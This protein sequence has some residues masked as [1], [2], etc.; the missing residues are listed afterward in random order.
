MNSRWRANRIGLIDFW[1]YDE[2]EFYFLDGRILLRGANGSGKSVTM[3]SFIPLLLDGNMRPERLD[4]FGSKARKMENYLLEEGD[5]RDERTGYLYME[6]KRQEV[7]N[8]ITIGIGMRARRNKKMDVWYFAITDGRRIGEDFFLYKD[9]NN[10]IAYS[11]QELKNRIAEGGKFFDSQREYAEYVNKTLFGFETTDEY[12]EMLE[13]LIQLRTPKLSKDFK[14][15]I[16]NEILSSSL[17]TLTEDDLRP[18]SEA[19]ENMDSLKTMLDT[20]KESIQAARQIGRVFGQY[21]S[22]VLYDK[23]RFYKNASDE[24]DYLIKQTQDYSKQ[25]DECTDRLNSEQ[26]K[27]DK[28]IQEQEI[29]LEEKKSLDE[30]DA[31]KLKEEEQT[32]LSELKVNEQS[33]NEKEKQHQDKRQRRVDIEN[34]INIQKSAN[35]QSS[36]VIDEFLEEMEEQ[37]QDFVFDEFEFLKR[38]FSDNRE[39]ACDFKSHKHLLNDYYNKVEAGIDI[40]ENERNCKKEY[41]EQLSKTD[42]LLKERD[43]AEKEFGQA[44]ILFGEAKSEWLEKAYKWNRENK[45]LNIT[46]EGMQILSRVL[47]DFK[48]GEDFSEIKESIRNFYQNREDELR[49]EQRKAIQHHDEI[50]QQY[51]DRKSELIEWEEKKD[52]EPVHSQAVIDNRK[53]LDE[54]KIPYVQFYKAVD[55]DKSLSDEQA[56]YLEE[57]LLQ[58]GILDALIISE[59]YRERVLDI[60]EGLCDKYIFTDVQSVK[61][62]LLNVLD[63]DN[64]DSDINLYQNVY[65]VLSAV[66][67]KCLNSIQHSDEIKDTDAYNNFE[68]DISTWIAKDGK[69]RLGILEGT[70]T[71]QH[72]AKYIGAKA[73][74]RYRMQEIE[75]LRGECDLLKEE[76]SLA[77]KECERKAECLKQIKDEWNIFPAGDDVKTAAR[78][79]SDKEYEL[80][81]LQVQVEKQRE[82]LEELRQQLEQIHT[83]VLSICKKTYLTIRLDVFKTAIKAIGEYKNSL[84]GLEIEH[85]RY[86]N[87]LESLKVQ[88]DY[89]EEVEA[90][91]D[92]ILYDIN[93][94]KRKIGELKSRIE[95]IQ[96]QLKLTNYEEIK[97]RLDYCITRLKQIPK[98]REKSAEEKGTLQQKIEELKTKISDS[99]GRIIQKQKIKECYEKAFS[100]EIKLWYVEAVKEY[101]NQE[102]DEKSFTSD[103]YKVADKVLKLLSE[104]VSDKRQSDLLSSFQEVY[105][106]NRGFLLGY[107]LTLKNIFEETEEEIRLGLNIH[108]IDIEAKYR[109]TALPF[110]ELLEKLIADMDTQSKLISEKDRE[111]FEDILANTIS[112]K[113]RARIQASKKWVE[114]MNEMMESMQTSSGL[115]LSLKWKNKRAD[116][117]EQ[118]DTKTLVE[119]LQKDSEIMREEETASLSMHFRSKI[120]EARKLSDEAYSA[121]SF[122]M[123]IKEVLDYRKWF[124]FQIE[125]QKTGE[126]KRE[127]TDRVFF[128]FSGGE[129]AMSMY[130]PLFSAV[131]A[132]YAGARQDAPHLISLDEAFAGVDEMNIKDMFRLMVE[133]GFDFMINSQILWGDYETIPKLA[134]YHLIRPENA[135]YVSVITYVWNGKGRVLVKRIGDEIEF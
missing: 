31:T 3:Q 5:G 10:K 25:K 77:E 76:L 50:V 97:E 13:L 119:L 24:Y 61:D 65:S 11:R 26:E 12:K 58:M 66:G 91:I 9:V 70:I 132:K 39:K 1:Y 38:E 121:Q 95:S 74:E 7:D 113:I 44:D 86:L 62:N 67:S 117:E 133:F 131:A 75:R 69:Y 130:V 103:I 33:L 100:D 37:V 123:I 20:L 42:E 18:M 32:V 108:R 104:E 73:R 14:P 17:Q 84:T 15:T 53:F 88:N 52:A 23:A 4:P 98:E 83:K 22:I 21:N 79:Y 40:L 126:K 114:R 49:E 64:A 107:N 134:I 118:M 120:Q 124:E 27:T 129:K 92:N 115:R 80:G 59:E 116:N 112:K 127:L 105:H 19:I 109:G 8:Y 94:S 56:S 125:C 35:E 99:E 57:A 85:E 51:E 82:K 110:N 78:V 102:K 122:Y 45:E 46:S 71:R 60:D 128:T 81:L 34:K 30:N 90:D 106:Q 68:S 48:H 54:H 29:L 63:I 55:F 16:I 2:E 36:T 72:R 41:D 135:K 6:F 47:E 87:G 101:F 28:L 93:K 96:E 89:L 43:H 111:I